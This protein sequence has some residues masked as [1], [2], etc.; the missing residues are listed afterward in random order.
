MPP[1]RKTS[2]RA[3]LQGKSAAQAVTDVAD[4]LSGGELSS[5]QGGLPD[6]ARE[7]YQLR[8]SRRAMACQFEIFLNAGQHERDSTAACEAL[9]LV[10]ELEEQLSIY[11][12]SS[13]ISQLNR[14]AGAEGVRVEPRLFA[15]LELALELHR[16]TAGAFDVTAGPLVRAWGFV[17]RQGAMP[18]EAALEVARQQVGS[19]HIKLERG[20]HSIRCLQPGIE[21]NLGSIGKG[22]ALDRCAELLGAAGIADFLLHGGNS[23]VLARGACVEREASVAANRETEPAAASAP[24]CEPAASGVA[25]CRDGWTIGV[26]NPYRPEQR[27]G[28]ILLR[29]RALA[30]SGSGTQFFVH[31]GR[32][33]GHI[34]DP[35]SGWP[36]AGVLSATALAPSAAVADALSTAFYV[37]GPAGAA[38]FCARHSEV[39]CLLVLPGER[40]ATIE[41][42]SYGLADGEFVPA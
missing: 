26:R 18:D 9:D 40:H 13:E 29:D 39:G 15:L 16:E 35:R 7:G 31:E 4:A 19:K 24:D 34:L 2:R 1:K 27:I 6:S 11:R 33:Y 20:A 25:A 12:D 14:M 8:L 21:I 36:A 30:T 42:A 23:S 10:E 32:R 41:I 38:E 3:F 22:Y 28:Q 37:L 5:G 17:R